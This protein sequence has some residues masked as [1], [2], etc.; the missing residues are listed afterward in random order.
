MLQMDAF[1]QATQC[2]GVCLKLMVWVNVPRD[3]CEWCKQPL[4]LFLT[5]CET[6]ATIKTR[7]KPPYYAH[8]QFLCPIKLSEAAMHPIPNNDEWVNDKIILK[9]I[10]IIIPLTRACH[11]QQYI[12]EPT[13]YLELKRRQS[14]FSLQA[15]SKEYNVGVVYFCKQ[16]GEICF[17]HIM[18]FQ[19]EH[20]KFTEHVSLSWLS[21]Q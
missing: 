4:L 19:C 21:C 13:D 8:V 5:A 11:H 15:R 18:T 14:F 2:A 20:I 3:M 17:I 9:I 7:P 16:I 12:N 6:A 1:L 10:L